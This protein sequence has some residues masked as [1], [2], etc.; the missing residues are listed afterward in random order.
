[1]PGRTL[2]YAEL[3]ELCRRAGF[4]DPYLAAAVAMAE[5]GGRIDAVNR[6]TNGSVDRGVFQINSIHGAL[7]TFDLESNIAAALRISSGG[8]DWSPWVA[9]QSGAHNQ[10]L[11]RSVRGRATPGASRI[12]IRSTP[13]TSGEVFG[14]EQRSGALRALLWVVFVFGGAILSL[15]GFARLT[16]VNPGIVIPGPV[17]K[18]A[19]G[20][21]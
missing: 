3:V 13:T 15:A 19:R 11:D 8:R 21:S 16:G 18:V 2:S 17:S 9:Y 10:F 14:P 1:V 20:V 6:N 12:P 7:S 5:S 4:P